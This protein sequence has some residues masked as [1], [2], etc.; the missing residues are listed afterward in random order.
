[1]FSSTASKST[2][3]KWTEAQYEQHLMVYLERKEL[4]KDIQNEVKALQTDLVQYMQH[5]DI[6]SAVTDHNTITLTRT[7]KWTYSD[8][9][10]R[11]SKRID[12]LRKIEQA[13]GVATSIE[14]VHL[15]VR[16]KS[17][18]EEED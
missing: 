1:M 3:K 17:Q 8:E 18:P 5:H 16:A 9:L 10:R 15:T 7:R 13:E 11:E 4:L 6:Q 14:S 2:A 12:N